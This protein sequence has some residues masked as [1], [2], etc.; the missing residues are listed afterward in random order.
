E[1]YALQGYAEILL[2]DFFCSGVPLST[3][4]FQKDYTYHAG[5]T[6]DSVYWDALNKLDIAVTLAKSSDS[7]GLQDLALV[8]K[9]RAF[10]ALGQYDS[11][12]A[13]VTV[14]PIKYTDSLDVIFLQEVGNSEENL[15]FGQGI[16]NLKGVYGL[17]FLSSGDPRT[18][19]DT[20]M[21]YEQLT[22]KEVTEVLP[23]IYVQQNNGSA[24]ATF[25]VA[26][27]IEARLIQ[28]EAAL[29]DNPNDGKW[30]DILNDLRATAPVPGTTQPATAQQLPMLS[31]P[32]TSPNEAAR[33]SLLFRE[34]AFWLFVT[35]HRQGDLRRLVREYGLNQNRVYPSGEYSYGVSFGSDVSAPIPG[36][37]YINPLF[38]GC[39]GRRDL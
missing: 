13:A 10:L 15:F 8:L 37:E 2:A 28:A 3:L 27:G 21:S 32:G 34:R 9:G 18:A 6:T 5:S 14:V 30:V 31:D 22:G 25:V 36:D 29:H 12:A 20:V 1:L 11:A 17:P 39:L 33:V 4:D 16:A 24:Y 38:K 26:S 23:K 7:V 19:G 35:A